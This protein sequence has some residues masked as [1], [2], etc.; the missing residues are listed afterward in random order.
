MKENRVAERERTVAPGAA[1]YV[2]RS[3]VMSGDDVRR[4]VTR[5]AHEIVERNHGLTDVV[6]VALQT[7]GAPLTERIA[8]E[9]GRIEGIEV[10]TGTL[11]VFFLKLPVR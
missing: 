7:G 11:D 2:S 3:Q 4:A 9:L 5:I 1:V 8:A 6:L 10:P